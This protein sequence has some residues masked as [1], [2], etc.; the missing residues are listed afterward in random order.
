MT[1][2]VAYI[3]TIRSKTQQA[4]EIPA[5]IARELKRWK[6]L[7]EGYMSNHGIDLKVTPEIVVFSNPHNDL[8]G[9][10]YSSY[11][12]GWADI[13]EAVKD[14][15]RGHRCSP[16]PYTIYSMRSTFIEDHALKGTP[17]FEVAEMAGH[18]VIETQKTKRPMRD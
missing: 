2:E 9:Y 1:W 11:S 4:R 14:K 18:S 3:Y 15:M 10:S 8:K 5:N 13:R 12:R 16:H 17:V 7:Q 6:K